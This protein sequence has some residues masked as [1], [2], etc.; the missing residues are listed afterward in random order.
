MFDKKFLRPHGI[1]RFCQDEILEKTYLE[2]SS[3]GLMR[4]IF[5]NGDTLITLN[6][7]G[8]EL[9]TIWFNK[10]FVE[11]IREGPRPEL[12]A[13]ISPTDFMHQ[14]YTPEESGEEELYDAEDL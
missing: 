3:V 12:L 6:K 2:D 8:E 5:G 7:D 1:V 4:N 11:E 14:N 10:N 13:D 9:A